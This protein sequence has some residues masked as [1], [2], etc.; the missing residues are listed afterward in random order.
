ML[1]LNSTYTSS[2][3]TG[4]IPSC[5]G[6]VVSFNTPLSPVRSMMH[7]VVRSTG[8]SSAASSAPPRRGASPSK[9]RWEREL[10]KCSPYHRRGGQL[11]MAGEKNDADKADSARL[12]PQPSVRRVHITRSPRRRIF[13]AR[14]HSRRGFSSFAHLQFI[15]RKL[16]GI[17]EV[18][19][20]ASPEQ[21]P[22]RTASTLTRLLLACFSFT[23]QCRRAAEARAFVFTLES[24]CQR[25]GATPPAPKP[26]AV[27]CAVYAQLLPLLL[28]ISNALH[29]AGEVGV[30][31]SAHSRQFVCRRIDPEPCS[32]VSESC[33]YLQQICSQLH[34]C[35]GIH[36]KI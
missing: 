29:T 23:L 18:F 30:V 3:A 27:A 5:P 1:P 34:C 4:R 35:Q 15:R 25:E 32:R 12:L 11:H 31:K 14:P 9:I 36:H 33:W 7:G 26:W 17:K 22:A 13:S 24:P 21:V 16:R 20:W 8:G 19:R 28:I 10:C 6:C 2:F